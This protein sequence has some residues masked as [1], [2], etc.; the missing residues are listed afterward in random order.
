MLSTMYNIC[1]I[2]IHEMEIE[3]G[4]IKCNSQCVK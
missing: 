4:E 2:T 1:L 3:K